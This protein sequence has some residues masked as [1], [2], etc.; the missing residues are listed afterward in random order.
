MV[1]CKLGQVAMDL[2]SGQ[3]CFTCY[4]HAMTMVRPILH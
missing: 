2:Y 4:Y 3:G 1:S